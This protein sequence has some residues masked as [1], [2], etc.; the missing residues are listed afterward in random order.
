[1]N[2]IKKIIYDEE[3]KFNGK[4]YCLLKI[5]PQD[6]DFSNSNIVILFFDKGATLSHIIKKEPFE[7]YKFNDGKTTYFITR[8]GVDNPLIVK[9]ECS[10][11]NVEVHLFFK[12][13]M[14]LCEYI[15]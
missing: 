11:K 5:K 8:D 14:E 2:F 3:F 6:E 12:N 10:E 4:K 9:Y 13:Y 1:M 7:N 15:F